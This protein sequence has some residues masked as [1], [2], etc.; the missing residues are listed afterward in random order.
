MNTAIYKHSNHCLLVTI[1]LSQWNVQ[2]SIQRVN[3]CYQKHVY[4]IQNA[5][6][7]LRLQRSS[8]GVEFALLLLC[9]KLH[10][11]TL[12]ISYLEGSS[13]VADDSLLSAD[14]RDLLHSL[15]H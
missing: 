6:T 7:S 4:I 15:F 10:V 11:C 9:L 3:N 5:A 1:R 2:N 12:S 14:E 13:D 8:G